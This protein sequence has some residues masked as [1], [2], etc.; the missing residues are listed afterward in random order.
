VALD[1]DDLRISPRNGTETL[2]GRPTTTSA[3]VTTIDPSSEQPLADYDDTLTAG[4]RRHTRSRLRYGFGAAVDPAGVASHRRGADRRRL[5][6]AA[7]AAGPP[8]QQ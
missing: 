3:K 4:D 7:L 2:T 6:S 8:C 5:P 1:V